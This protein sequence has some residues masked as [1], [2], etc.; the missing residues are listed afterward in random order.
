MSLQTRKLN[1]IAYLT[2]LKDEKLFQKIEASI[3]SIKEKE[4]P[5]VFS[6]EE[7]IL[8]AEEANSDYLKGKYTSQE[9]LEKESE[10]W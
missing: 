5:S 10:S 3:M 2:S 9:I 7:L 1:L 4:K 6:E 8:R